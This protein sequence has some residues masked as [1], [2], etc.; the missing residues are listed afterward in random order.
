[1]TVVLSKLVAGVFLN[2]C[3]RNATI[4]SI[5]RV[6]FFQTNAALNFYINLEDLR[7]GG[8][9]T[10]RRILKKYNCCIFYSS[11]SGQ[12]KMAG[13]C[14]CGNEPSS[15]IK[16]TEFL[17]YLKNKLLR[18]VT[19]NQFYTLHSVHYTVVQFPQF[20]PTRVHCNLIHNNIFFF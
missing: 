11:A 10:L 7:V 2:T 12:R 3:I 15:P 13:S 17:V 18:R 19:F 6:Y 4:C 1:M 5:K 14:T 16:C 20:Q 8:S 9:I